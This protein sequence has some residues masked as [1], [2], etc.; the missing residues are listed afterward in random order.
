MRGRNPEEDRRGRRKGGPV[1]IITE[2][3][4]WGDIQ[5]NTHSQ[6]H[7]PHFMLD[8]PVSIAVITSTMDRHS[9]YQSQRDIVIIYMGYKGQQPSHHYGLHQQFV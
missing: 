7:A 5:P 2:L 9:Q 8:T 1:N 3:Q 4:S 6:T